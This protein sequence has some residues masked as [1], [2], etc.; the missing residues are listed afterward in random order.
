M[1]IE[2]SK[3]PADRD[4]ILQQ[5]LD[6]AETLFDINELQTN[7]E[8]YRLLYELEYRAKTNESISLESNGLE[9][10][11]DLHDPAFTDLA[12]ELYSS[13][14]PELLQQCSISRITIRPDIIHL[15]IGKGLYLTRKEYDVWRNNNPLVETYKVRAENFT[16]LQTTG[17]LQ[18]QFQISDTPPLPI[19]IYGFENDEHSGVRHLQGV[20]SHIQGKMYKFGTVTHEIG[21]HIFQFVLTKEQKRAVAELATIVDP[22][23]EYAQSYHNQQMYPEEQFCEAV[24]LATT[25]PKYLKDTAP[26][27]YR[28][29]EKVLPGI[30]MNQVV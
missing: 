30:R 24:R 8:I 28:W 21:H 19:V 20:S 29:F 26:E 18:D 2:N 11:N 14:S 17:W 9:I 12:S 10:E 7:E 27:M 23:T 4:L 13:I 22:I 3:I 5:L 6:E 25:R 1:S 15:A 16:T